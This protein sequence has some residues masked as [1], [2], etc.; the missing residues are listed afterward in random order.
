MNSYLVLCSSRRKK[1]NRQKLDFKRFWG[2]ETDVP[3][4]LN[5]DEKGTREEFE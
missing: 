4:E 5:N 1:G 2:P 3:K